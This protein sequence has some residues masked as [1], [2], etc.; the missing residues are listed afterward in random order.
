[1]VCQ[2]RHTYPVQVGDMEAGEAA[3]LPAGYSQRHAIPWISS[4]V[5]LN[6]GMTGTRMISL[7][8][9]E[10]ATLRAFSIIRSFGLTSEFLMFCRIG[11]LDIHQIQIKIWK[12]FLDHLKRCTC[13]ALQ[14]SVDSPL[15]GSSEEGL[16]RT[17]AGRGSHLRRGSDRRRNA[18]STGDP[19]QPP[20][21]SLLL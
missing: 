20:G 5:S 1:M 8:L 3:L 10:S 7:H 6:V 9:P 4:T 12:D 2:V 15:L 14:G 16:W 21:S 11:M 13:H 18:G 19:V 17:P